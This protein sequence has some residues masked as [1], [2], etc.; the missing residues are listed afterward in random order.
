M[1]SHRENPAGLLFVN[2]EIG[3][4]DGYSFDKLSWFFG[5]VSQM[6]QWFPSPDFAWMK[7]DRCLAPACL[8]LPQEVYQSKDWCSASRIHTW[9]SFIFISKTFCM[10]CDSVKR[11]C[12]VWFYFLRWSMTHPVSVSPEDWKGYSVQGALFAPSLRAGN[13]SFS[14]ATDLLLPLTHFSVANSMFSSPKQRFVSSTRPNYAVSRPFHSPIF[15]SCWQS[16]QM[17]AKRH[18]Q[19]QKPFQKLHFELLC[20]Q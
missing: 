9:F 6:Q 3:W 11:K 17:K 20:S 18:F 8:R 1:P 12:R 10:C 14:L 7:E 4:G 19:L 15:P 13:S 2:P 5:Q 16:K